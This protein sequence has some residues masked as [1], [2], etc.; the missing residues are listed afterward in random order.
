[1]KTG[2]K[3]PTTQDCE[4][5]KRET[6]GNPEACSTRLKLPILAGEQ[7]VGTT[8]DRRG[9]FNRNGPDNCRPRYI[10]SSYVNSRRLT[11]Q[12]RRAVSFELTPLVR[13]EALLALPR[14]RDRLIHCL[15]VTRHELFASA[16]RISAPVYNNY[17]RGLAGVLNSRQFAGQL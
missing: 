16:V 7:S 11:V 3:V 17:P 10:E 14:P 12:S 6:I 15:I 4:S 5:R 13:T 8:K 1:M 9:L 2:D